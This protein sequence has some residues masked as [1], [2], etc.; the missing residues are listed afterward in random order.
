MNEYIV[1]ITETTTSYIRVVA[2]NQ[3]DAL[4]YADM[5]YL[6]GDLM[7]MM[8][9][10]APVYSVQIADTHSRFNTIHTMITITQNSRGIKM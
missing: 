7:Y 10:S 8:D 3:D 2:D 1:Q 9:D 6:E 4:S 5:L